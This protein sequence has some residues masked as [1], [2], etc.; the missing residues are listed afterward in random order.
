VLP[1][2]RPHGHERTAAQQRVGPHA[3]P[4]PSSHLGGAFPSTHSMGLGARCTSNVSTERLRAAAEAELLPPAG[5]AAA[6]AGGC[7]GGAACLWPGA[8]LV[9]RLTL[10]FK[11]PALERAFQHEWDSMRATAQDMQGAAVYSAMVSGRAG[12][13]GLGHLGLG[14]GPGDHAH[15][16]RQM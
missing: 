5:L 6:S 8:P 10:R 14:R 3:G 1:A 12:L 7:S 16:R 2:A 15:R 4:A 9:D 11:Q 13:G